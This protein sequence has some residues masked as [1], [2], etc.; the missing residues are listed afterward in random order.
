MYAPGDID[1]FST[2]M[3]AIVIVRGGLLGRMAAL[4]NTVL[5]P[6]VD[7][8]EPAQDVIAGNYGV[9][10]VPK[11]TNAIATNNIGPA[12]MIWNGEAKTKRKLKPGDEIRLVALCSTD[13]GAGTV[14]LQGMFQMFQIT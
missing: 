7:I 6:V 2:I 12:T 1:A 11:V 3:W 8:Y 14:P 5:Q 10:A 9:I 13:P 4:P